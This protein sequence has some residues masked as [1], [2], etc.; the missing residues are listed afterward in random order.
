MTPIPNKMKN[1]ILKN[2]FMV[3]MICYYSSRIASMALICIALQAG[4][5]PAKRPDIIMIIVATI[6]AKIIYKF[7]D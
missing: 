6:D 3:I 1:K 2:F 4:N 5:T 7:R